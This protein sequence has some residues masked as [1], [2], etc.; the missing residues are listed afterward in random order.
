MAFNGFNGFVSGNTDV[1]SNADIDNGG[2][3]RPSTAVRCEES[4]LMNRSA[5]AEVSVLYLSWINQQLRKEA[6]RRETL[7]AKQSS[8]ATRMKTYLLAG[9]SATSLL[10]IKLLDL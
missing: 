7:R 10:V 1:N 5:S 2:P 8:T 4:Y 3:Y 6:D 9:L